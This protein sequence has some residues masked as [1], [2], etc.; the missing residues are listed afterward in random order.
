MFRELF[1]PSQEQLYFH[2][3]YAKFIEICVVFINIWIQMD[4][5]LGSSLARKLSLWFQCGWIRGKQLAYVTP[6][7]RKKRWYS[8]ATQYVVTPGL[9]LHSVTYWEC[10][11]KGLRAGERTLKSSSRELSFP[12]LSLAPPL[13]VLL[14]LFVFFAFLQAQIYVN[15]LKNSDISLWMSLLRL[16]LIKQLQVYELL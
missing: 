2:L 3:L 7:L 5:T 6:D 11:L 15:G 8:S 9:Q 1:F 12:T 16:C 10:M 4:T 13:S 14:P